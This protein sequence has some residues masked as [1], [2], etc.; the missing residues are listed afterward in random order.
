M[1]KSISIQCPECKRHQII[2]VKEEDFN[3]WRSGTIIQEAFP[4]L[5]A[6][7]REALITGLCQ[8]CWDNIM[9]V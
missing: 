4:Y 1:N 8:Q 7:Q 9:D 2:E 3:K 5:S 6:S